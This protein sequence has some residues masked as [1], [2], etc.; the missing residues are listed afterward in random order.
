MDKN[1]QKER[2]EEAW[3]FCKFCRQPDNKILDIILDKKKWDKLPL[4]HK[5]GWARIC[6]V[7]IKEK[8]QHDD[9]W[10]S[11]CSERS[12][13]NNHQLDGSSNYWLEDYCDIYKKV[14]DNIED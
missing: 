14:N 5:C 2:N 3:F 12:F 4:S 7:A 6:Q 9:I 13:R 1:E 8:I 11:L 10:S